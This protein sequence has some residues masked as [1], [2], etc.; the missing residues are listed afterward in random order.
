MYDSKE[1]KIELVKETIKQINDKN[2]EKFVTAA[3]DEDRSSVVIT[4]HNERFEE[5]MKRSEEMKAYIQQ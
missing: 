5:L 4:W 1:D 3:N 2:V